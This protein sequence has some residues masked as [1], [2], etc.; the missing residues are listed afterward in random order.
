MNHCL[1]P[2]QKLIGYAGKDELK[3]A[4]EEVLP[5]K[6][7]VKKFV[8]DFRE[9]HSLNGRTI[10]PVLPLLKLG[11][12]SSNRMANEVKNAL[13]DIMKRQIATLE[14]EALQALLDKSYSF[15]TVP[16]LSPIGISVLER[17]HYVDRRIWAQ[18]VQ[19]GL[20]ESPY[21]DLPTSI[22][23]RIWPHEVSAFDHEIDK[24]LDCITELT[25]PPG[26]EAFFVTP[27]RKKARSEDPILTDLMRLSN[28]VA[29]E[30][31]M[32]ARIVDKF[33][34]KATAAQTGSKRIAIANVY[35]DFLTTV[36]PRV[37]PSLTSLRKMAKFLDT[38]NGEDDIDSDVLGF[39]RKN[40][41]V[42]ASCATVGLLV[43]SSY[44]RDFLAFQ[45]VL[46]LLNRRG[47]L[48]EGRDQTILD[49]AA[50]HLRADPWIPDLTF[51]TLCNMKA[52]ALI[53]EH[54]A[55]TETE[56]NM[57]FQMFFPLLIHEMELDDQR[58]S[59]QFYAM[60]AALP[61]PKFLQIVQAGKLERRV[62]TSYCLQLFGH[63]N[64]VGLSRFRLILDV[65]FHQMDREEEVR[66]TMI[67][68]NL[69]QRTI[70]EMHSGM[71]S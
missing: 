1:D 17:L 4:F 41:G 65:A 40:I 10:S 18:I 71:V 28:A 51:L 62:V 64:F 31:G 43:A 20:D 29:S 19:N 61:D 45:L 16:E 23:K 3:A 15:L 66:E 7:G 54:K 69:L 50:E 34:Q 46:R 22:K 37:N 67:A 2:G 35:H 53:S 24:V 12:I 25:T 32:V 44:S 47:S 52:A 33:V 36:N 8:K 57:P 26:I 38:P 63:G 21:T 68:V 11:G 60:N 9:V 70:E 27:D 56:A 14:Q 49:C 48:G 59:D 58:F 6:V 30:E 55:P 13:V 42:E 39:I 5:D